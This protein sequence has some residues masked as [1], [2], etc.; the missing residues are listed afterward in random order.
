MLLMEQADASRWLV[1][2]FATEELE[3]DCPSSFESLPQFVDLEIRGLD[4][5][6]LLPRV[7]NHLCTCA[8]CRDLYEGL[9]AVVEME[10]IGFLPRPEFKRLFND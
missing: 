2:I 3:L 10:Q 7:W 5:S 4:A 8:D 6:R 1:R 9:R